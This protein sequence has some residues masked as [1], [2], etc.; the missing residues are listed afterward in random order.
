LT[1]FSGH[2]KNVDTTGNEVVTYPTPT[3]LRRFDNAQFGPLQ[4]STHAVELHYR[5][6]DNDDFEYSE[7]PASYA[8]PSL[9][10]TSDT[11]SYGSGDVGF[12][13]I[14]FENVAALSSFTW[15]AI[16]WYEAI[17]PT[18]M[19]PT[20]SQTDLQGLGIAMQSKDPRVGTFF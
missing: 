16:A 13:I 1:W 10:I 17:G 12:M 9:A 6:I 14:A 7:R 15:E 11:T 3:Q 18:M 4:P 20:P 8:L 2:S 19:G 5:P